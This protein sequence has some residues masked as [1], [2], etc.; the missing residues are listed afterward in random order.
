M[1]RMLINATHDEE[2]RVALVDGQILYDLDIENRGKEQKK[3]NIYKARVTRLEPSLEAAFVDF[4]GV[5]HGFLPFRQISPA[6][7][8]TIPGIDKD[9]RPGGKA[10]IQDLIEEGQELIVQ[11]VKEERSNKG[12]ALTTFC[13]LAGRYLV[14]TPNNPRTGGISRKIEG[15]ERDQ[16]R[17]MLSQL[18]I[19]D[20]MGLIV[21]TAGIERNT[22]ELQWDLDYLVRLYHDITTAAESRE[23][24]FLIYQD[25]DVIIR[26]IRDYMRDDIDEILIDTPEAH[27]QAKDFI[28][29]VMPRFKSR[30]QLYTD[31]LPLFSRYQIERQI[32]SAFQ[33]EVRL[34]SGGS[35]VIDQTEALVSIDINSARATR[36]ADIEETALNTNLEAVEE[37]CRHLRLRDIG[38]LIVIDFIDMAS[39]KNQRTIEQQMQDAT[40]VDRAR[41]QISKISTFGLMEMSRQRLRPSLEESSGIVCPRCEGLGTIKDA[42]STA[43]EIIRL[44]EEE[45]LKDEGALIRASLPVHLA[46]FLINEKRSQII[47]IEQQNKVRIMLLPEPQMEIPHYQV[48]RIRA[49]DL[50]SKD[51]RYNRDGSIE[52]DTY[53]AGMAAASSR[54]AAP[55]RP[56]SRREAEKA[57]VPPVLSNMKSPRR[58]QKSPGQGWFARMLRAL[59]GTAPA[60]P[61]RPSSRRPNKTPGRPSG[62][63]PSDGHKSSRSDNRNEGRKSSRNNHRKPADRN[64]HNDGNRQNDQ[65]RNTKQEQRTQQNTQPP[66]AQQE[67]PSVN[68]SVNNSASDTRPPERG[69]HQV[70]QSTAEQHQHR[71]AHREAQR[72]EQRGSQPEADETLHPDKR[73]Q[74][75]R[76]RNNQKRRSQPQEH[77][78][79]PGGLPAA[80]AEKSAAERSATESQPVESRTAGSP[81]G[82]AVTTEAAPT[83]PAATPSEPPSEPNPAVP[84]GRVGNDPRTSPA[85][86]KADSLVLQALPSREEA[87]APPAQPRQLDTAHP[88]NL[89]RVN[90]DPR[91]QLP[92]AP[93]KAQKETGSP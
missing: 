53:A 86:P 76:Q 70:P 85:E 31:D 38:G 18:S 35:L 61:G 44:I 3:S 64:R 5:R 66:S 88:G 19:P 39:T 11:V 22:E 89:G 71:E 80:N 75:N 8:S 47:E 65:K 49:Q 57:L 56:A 52:A 84:L 20:N 60:T 78:E 41:I 82:M 33:R 6:C 48:E 27:T 91:Y 54:Q 62:R 79:T 68:N 4:G 59:F 29:Q 17:D 90:N 1:K 2:L 37:I 7:Y 40:R 10:R 43:M 23:A 25:S 93:A 24:P 34:P 74:G 69:N 51:T 28:S 73:N 87:T 36:G 50:E 13:S 55:R 42:S 21:R 67:K 77:S 92:A 15:P 9:T 83:Q 46:A 58:L 81:Q 16:L 63:R 45:A 30:C 12:A 32:E 26:A 14:L 72:E